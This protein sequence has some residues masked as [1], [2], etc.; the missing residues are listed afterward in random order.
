[1]IVTGLFFFLATAVSAENV[2]G[3]SAELTQSSKLA[4]KD[5][6]LINDLRTRM[7]IKSVLEKYNSPLVGEVDSFMAA[8]KKYDLDCYLLPSI[9]GLE[10]TFGRFIYPNSYNP[11]GWGGGLIMFNKWSDGIDTVASGLRNN[12]INKGATSIYEIGH[13]YS[14][15]PTWATRVSSIMTQFQKEEEKYPLLPDKFSI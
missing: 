3:N 9:S 11:F 6:N 4:V 15:S 1:M 2:A 8:C 7:V 5:G 13:I 12:Y 14:E 10:S